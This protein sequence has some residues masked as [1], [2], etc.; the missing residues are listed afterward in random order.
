[1]SKTHFQNSMES[2]LNGLREE[3]NSA[4]EFWWAENCFIA[5]FFGDR[6]KLVADTLICDNQIYT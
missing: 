5:T 1:M 3:H 6:F 2:E 4:D